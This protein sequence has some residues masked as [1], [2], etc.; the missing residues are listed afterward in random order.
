LQWK[1]N[2][3][4]QNA[5]RKNT[6]AIDLLLRLLSLALGSLAHRQSHAS[7]ILLVVTSCSIPRCVIWSSDIVRRNLSK[8]TVVHGRENSHE[9]LQTRRSE[10]L[11]SRWHFIVAVVATVVVPDLR[12][13][14]RL[15]ETKINRK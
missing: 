1:R 12:V 15:K 2:K 5:R 13:L 8:L 3:I 9:L 6:F 14:L 10:R 11:L 4:K 7:P